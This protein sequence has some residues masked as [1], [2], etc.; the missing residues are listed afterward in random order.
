MKGIVINSKVAVT[1][2]LSH[3]LKILW[4]MTPMNML[5]ARPW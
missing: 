2:V 3:P 5:K 4:N 1:A